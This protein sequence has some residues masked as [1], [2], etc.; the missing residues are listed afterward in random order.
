MHIPVDLGLV[1]R[2]Y[3]FL[4]GG[5]KDRATNQDVGEKPDMRKNLNIGNALQ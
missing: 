4:L 5:R 3:E 1:I 2:V